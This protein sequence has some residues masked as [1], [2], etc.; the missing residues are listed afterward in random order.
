M[1]RQIGPSTRRPGAADRGAAGNLGRIAISGP[2]ATRAAGASVPVE[3]DEVLPEMGL[4]LLTPGADLG[5]GLVQVQ[6][7]VRIKL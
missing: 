6:R 2:S 3:T 5:G 4:H 7:F 1:Q